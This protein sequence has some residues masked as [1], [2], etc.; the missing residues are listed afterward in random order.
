MR[1]PDD[2]AD[3]GGSRLPEVRLFKAEEQIDPGMNK[4]EK[5]KA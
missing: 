1:S 4:M 2:D 5:K 3:P